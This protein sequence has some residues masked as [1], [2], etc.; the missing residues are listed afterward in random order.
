MSILRIARDKGEIAATASGWET[1]LFNGESYQ[2]LASNDLGI[3]QSHITMLEDN[4]RLLAACLE[5][6]MQP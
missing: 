2:F 4:N 1:K 6:E 3:I 5:K